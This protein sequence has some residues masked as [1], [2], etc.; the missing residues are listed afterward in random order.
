MKSSPGPR[1]RFDIATGY[2][3]IMSTEAYSVTIPASDGYMGVLPGHMPYITP[4]VAGRLIARTSDGL[5]VWKTGQG[6][7]V[8]GHER[9]IVLL[10]EPPIREPEPDQDRQ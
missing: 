6:L 8:I 10:H 2:E 7:V 5:V 9:V 4:L 3:V 1:F